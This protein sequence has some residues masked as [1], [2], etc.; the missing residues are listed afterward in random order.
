MINKVILVGNLGKDPETRS[1]D[2]DKTVCKF[3][4]ATSESYKDRN[5]NKIENTEWHNIEM[6][7][8][9]AKVAGQ[10]LTKGSKVYLEGKIKTDE[11][12]KDGIKRYSTKIVAN[13]MKMLDGKKGESNEGDLPF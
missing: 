3:T 12:E 5:G 4:V 1:L 7:G 8:G 9:L 10:Y 2:N 6:W 13:E 11:Y